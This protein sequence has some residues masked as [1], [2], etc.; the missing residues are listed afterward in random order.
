MEINTAGNSH[1][2]L[3]GVQWNYGFVSSFVKPKA[4][5][6]RI[7]SHLKVTKRLVARRKSLCKIYPLK[8]ELPTNK[9]C[10]QLN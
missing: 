6:L 5:R 10:R 8:T 1:F 9:L 3:A 4:E 2:E 7:S